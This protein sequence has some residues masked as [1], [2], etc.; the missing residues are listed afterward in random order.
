MNEKKEIKKM[1]VEQTEDLK[2][3]NVVLYKY[4]YDIGNNGFNRSGESE[5]NIVFNGTIQDCATFIMLYKSED[6]ILNMNKKTN[7]IVG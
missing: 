1:Y 2:M 3:F 7:V 4:D 6:L 5:S